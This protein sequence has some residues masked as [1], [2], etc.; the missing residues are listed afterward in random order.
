MIVDA[1]VYRD[2]NHSGSEG[3][4]AK[5]RTVG[6]VGGK[7]WGLIDILNPNCDLKDRKMVDEA[8]F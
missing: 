1:F 8:H 4:N 7:L 6:L 5:H 2:N 3:G